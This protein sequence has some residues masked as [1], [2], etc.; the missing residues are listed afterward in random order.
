MRAYA[1][2]N[3]RWGISNH[4]FE[5][6]FGCELMKSPL[7]KQIQKLIQYWLVDAF[8]DAEGSTT[9]RIHTDTTI[10]STVYSK[11]FYSDTITRE[12][13][14]TFL[15]DSPDP[16]ELDEKLEMFFTSD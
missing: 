9:Y 7:S 15:K 8:P 1:I 3:I 4:K 11:F 2:N 5:S 14:K 16:A 13:I 6:L 12:C 10:A